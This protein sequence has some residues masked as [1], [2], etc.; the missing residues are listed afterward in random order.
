M[1]S[2]QYGVRGSCRRKYGKFITVHFFSNADLFGINTLLGPEFQKLGGPV[3]LLNI[4]VAHVQ[5]L[6]MNFRIIIGMFQ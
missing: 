4:V 1:G 2:V 6:N 5:L 3:L